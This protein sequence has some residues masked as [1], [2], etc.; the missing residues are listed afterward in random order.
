MSRRYVLLPLI[1][2]AA[3]GILLAADWWIALPEDIE[4]AFVGRDECARCHEEE[5]KAWTGSDHDRAMD[6]ATPETVLGNFNDQEFTHQGTGPDQTGPDPA[7]PRPFHGVTSKMSR[8][9]KTFQIT[10]DNAKGQIETLPIKYV[11]GV[12][13]LQQYLV[14]FPDGRVQCLP[15]TWDT[16]GKRWYHLYPNEDIPFDDEL[17]WTRPSQNWNYMCASCHS[18]NLQK[19]YDLKTDTYHTTFSE[20]DVS[21]EACHGPGSTHVKLADSKSLF[22]DR[23]HGYGL[24]SLKD[25]AKTQVETCAPCHS[26]HIVIYPGFQPGDEF[27]DHYVPQL[28]TAP[29]SLGHELYYADGQ[30]LD[31]DYVYG[32][33]IQ[34]KMYHNGVR[35]TDCHDPHTARVKYADPKGPL[36]QPI[37][38]RLCTDCHMQQHPAGKYDTA[39]HHFHPDS[40]KPGTRCVECH[41]PETTYMVVDPR[42]DHSMRIPRPE[43]TVWLGIPNACNQCHNDESKGETPEWAQQKVEEWYGTDKKT[44]HF[45]YAMDAGREHRPE[46]LEMLDSL[47]R[48]KDESGMVRASALTLL[49]R[50]PDGPGR[51]IVSRSLED[52]DPLVRLAAVRSLEILP[53]DE[54]LKKVV[55]LLDDPIRAV[56]IEAA[57]TLATVSKY[58]SSTKRRQAFDAALGEFMT[59]QRSRDDR[60]DSHEQ[61]AIMSINLGRLAEAERESR[62]A[63]RINPDFVPFRHTLS[64]ILAKQAYEALEQKRPEEAAKKNAE[65]EQQLR[66]IIELQP[67][68]GDAYYSLG[69]LLAEDEQRLSE[70]AEQLSKAAELI[71]NSPRVLCNLGAALQMLDRPAESERALLTAYRLAPQYAKCSH[72]LA[73]LYAQQEKWDAALQWAQRYAQLQP[74]DP[75]AR[76]FLR[77]IQQQAQRAAMEEAIKVGP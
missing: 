58:L 4:S 51:S 25:D 8:R 64:T 9:G 37:D 63:V 50:Y 68:W 5:M 20:I 34:S 52:P 19:K 23:R 22:W 61:M 48:R 6:F 45:A 39:A 13:P 32:S 56:R 69:L 24:P 66:K 42:R 38:N 10:T 18:T 12:Q 11:F 31:E 60:A 33:F 26:R 2:L 67:A 27:L 59:G 40:S 62:T 21:C 14:E 41:M 70:A 7:E 35:C 53:R 77:N 55:P 65:A 28:L 74:G 43:L 1:L 49:S 16:E 30:I 72:A 46:G 54:R 44:K 36:H 71:P 3:G 17:H 73:T 76:A 29:E 47:I 15:I 57:K 75:Q